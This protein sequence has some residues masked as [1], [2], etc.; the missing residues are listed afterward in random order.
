M[1]C[2]TQTKYSPSNCRDGYPPYIDLSLYDFLY[3]FNSLY[4]YESSHYE[5]LAHAGPERV[6]YVRHALLHNATKV[7]VLMPVSQLKW[8]RGI[9]WSLQQLGVVV[10]E[11]SY[12]REER[13]KG[14]SWPTNS[15]KWIGLSKACVGVCKACFRVMTL[16]AYGVR[17]PLGHN[18]TRHFCDD[19]DPDPKASLKNFP[20]SSVDSIRSEPVMHTHMRKRDHKTQQIDCT[21]V[22]VISR[23]GN[24]RA[25][26]YPEFLPDIPPQHNTGK[27]KERY[28]VKDFRMIEV[29]QAR[30]GVDA[31]RVYFGNTSTEEMLD[32]FGNACAIVGP[33]GAGFGNVLFAQPY[34]YVLEVNVYIPSLT[35]PLPPELVVRYESNIDAGVG[36]GATWDLYMIGLEKLTP[37]FESDKSNL[38]D[39]LKKEGNQP[40]L[41]RIAYGSNYLFE[42]EDYLSMAETTCM[43]VRHLS[44]HMSCWEKQLQS[45]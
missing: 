25:F 22:A 36:T 41:N 9:V 21:H 30:F 4:A 17:A 27:F 29:F 7:A 8:T 45:V 18:I 1:N 39:A 33:A 35:K 32:V 31:V 44:P 13:K 5:S 26:V 42:M 12:D 24:Y 3:D 16:A 19:G 23:L 37:P 38:T 6:Q 40:F 2:S 15:S 14:A 10:D 43:N 11:F 34:T 20:F 28:H